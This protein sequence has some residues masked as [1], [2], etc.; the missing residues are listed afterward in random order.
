MKLKL[1]KSSNGIPQ[2]IHKIE[3]DEGGTLQTLLYH[4]A[5]EQARTL[6]FPF[7][8]IVSLIVNCTIPIFDFK[9]QPWKV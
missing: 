5:A 6:F 2:K 8:T 3:G 9:S 4:R 7:F 1:P